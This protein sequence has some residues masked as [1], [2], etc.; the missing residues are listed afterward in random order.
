MQTSITKLRNNLVKGDSTCAL[1]EKSLVSD[2]T[3]TCLYL[4]GV[5]A[6]VPSESQMEKW[7]GKGKGLCTEE[8]YTWRD[9]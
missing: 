6:D 2:D 9:P 5:K 7:A 3:Y 8:Q 4:S 1:A